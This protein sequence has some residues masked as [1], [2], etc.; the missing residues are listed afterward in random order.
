MTDATLPF[1]RRLGATPLGDG[2]TTFR[3][4]APA[5]EAV[6]VRL[7]GGDAP[8]APVGH[9]VHEGVLPAV[10]G[11]DYHVVLDGEALWDPWSRWQPDGIDGAS[12]VLDPATFVWSAAAPEVPVEDLVI[13]E[14]HVGTFTAAGTFDAACA[15][16]P[17]LRGLGITAIELMPVAQFPGAHGWGYDGV[18]TAAAFSGY[19]GPAGLARFVDAAHAAGLLVVLDVVYNHVGAEGVETF[20]R[21]GPFFTDAHET[22]WGKAL[23]YDDA[24]CDAVREWAL[25]SAEGWLRDFRIDG[26]RLDA[27]HAIHD[28]SARPIVRAIGERARAVRPGAVVIAE[29]DLNDP[30]VI[31]PA[32]DGG[33]GMDAQWADEFH[34]ALHALLTGE[35][36]GYYADFG[37]VAQLAKAYH[38]PFVNDGGYSAFRDRRHGAPADDRAPLQFVVF[39]QNHD[40][41]GNRAFGDRLPA[42]VRPLA[43]FCVLLSP[44]VPL[45]FMGEEHG[46]PAPFQYFADHT[47]PKLVKAT[48]EGRRREFERFAAFAGREIPD[49]Q[50][51]A[52][53]EASRLTRDGDGALAALYRELLQARRELPHDVEVQTALDED[54]GWLRVERGIWTLAMNFGAAEA[55]VACRASEVR[56]AA[57][58]AR[59]DGETVVLAPLAGALLR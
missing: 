6:A 51:R 24:G 21:F 33:L 12:R 36:D 43:A 7:A 3:V 15:E 10:H 46:E 5:A 39:A 23:N 16:L 29:S 27:I 9:G 55:A 18:H 47:D 41:V 30:R 57:G 37:A 1:E 44:F 54:A 42:P 50:D 45:L 52:T 32:E 25:Q 2:T 40:Q 34:H 13:Y 48:R 35:R 4:W 19:G 28:E 22:F 56:L 53:F 31:R 38:R 17:A 58:A 49:P 59:L 14:L 20:E 26:L 8:L 11:D